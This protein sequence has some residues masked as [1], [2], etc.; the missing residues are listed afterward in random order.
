MFHRACSTIVD[1]ECWLSELPKEPPS[2]D[3][4]YKRWSGNLV[5]CLTYCIISQAFKGWISVS[6]LMIDILIIREGLTKRSPW[7]AF[8]TTILCIVNRGVRIEGSS[9]S[10]FTMQLSLQMINFQLQGPSILLVRKVA[11]ILRLAPASVGGMHTN[12]PVPSSLKIDKMVLTLGPHRLCQVW[13]WTY[14]SWM[15]DS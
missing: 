8:V 13:T 5:E 6:A 3:S 2:L 11:P 9:L 4:A 10:L 14:H 7:S 12:L 15:L 1:G